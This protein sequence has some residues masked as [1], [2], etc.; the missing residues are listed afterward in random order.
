MSRHEVDRLGARTAWRQ[1]AVS[2]DLTWQAAR[3]SAGALVLLAMLAGLAPVASAWLMKLVLDRL[4]SGADWSLLL[5]VGAG[6]AVVGV[7]T[8]VVPHLNQYAEGALN[9]AVR[10]LAFARLFQAINSRLRGLLKLEQ[11][12]FHDRLELAQDAGAAAPGQVVNGAL[13]ISRDTV[14]MVGFVGTLLALNP[15]LAV[16]VALAAVPTIRAEV[17]LARR[18]VSAMRTIAFATRRRFFYGNLLS[19]P[20]EAKEVR[21][22]GLGGFFR[23]R[24]LSEQQK[25]ND[26]EQ[27]VERRE[28]MVLAL[29]ALLAAGVAGGG[30]MW[31]IRAALVGTLTIGDISVFVAAV[32]GVQGALANIIATYGRV[33]QALLMLD[34]HQAV[35]TVEPDLP[36]P[37]AARAAP[38]LR[39]GIEVR[40][41]WFR[42]A[43]GRPWA[44]REVDLSIPVGNAVALVGRNGAGKSTLV[45][46]LCRL[47]D[48]THGQITWDGVDLREFDLE[49]LRERIGAVFQD[50]V[51][52]ELSAKENIGLGDLAAF[53]DLARIESAARRAG[54]HD[55]LVALPAGYDT[56]LTRMFFDHVST[57]DPETGVLLSGGQGQRLALARA[58]L[59]DRRDLLILDEPSAGLDA[60][61]EA[62]IHARLREHRAGQTSL[63]ISHRLNTVRDADTIIVLGGGRVLEQGDHASL[64]AGGGE[65][66]QLFRL[67][68]RGYLDTM[69]PVR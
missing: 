27:R 37:P 68:A 38:P 59:R 32:A 13:G 16:V 14:T 56:L 9:R 35:M 24:L 51:E 31:A 64:V 3:G 66:A 49:T 19:S 44:L 36:T 46:L 63:L 33:H 50:Y 65:Y 41:V 42:Y 1:L 47:Y 10:L 61:A 28:A 67:Q 5:G 45:K 69:E 43:E 54:V 55:T 18:R 40:G 8:G 17:L 7:V 11:P 60:A 48:P 15:V 25:V 52:Y 22:F 12:Q 39:K 23:E 53:D 2:V 21:L 58:F 57:D 6:L 20:Q 4:A 62:E 34:H 26:T 29:L 30:L